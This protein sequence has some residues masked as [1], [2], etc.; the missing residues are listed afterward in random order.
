ML[1]QW[2]SCVIMLKK[3]VVTF[4]RMG[5]PSKE[6]LEKRHQY[7]DGMW[8]LAVAYTVC[9]AKS[10]FL[11]VLAE[12]NKR[13]FCI[14]ARDHGCHSN[15]RALRCWT[16]ECFATCNGAIVVVWIA[17]HC[18]CMLEGPFGC[19]PAETLFLCRIISS[20]AVSH[21]FLSDFI[22]LPFWK[23]TFGI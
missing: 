12:K 23:K 13:R 11:G 22:L 4:A 17:L 18:L 19:F 10:R 21:P 14:P 15:V 20:F 1:K 16:F 5:S 6:A 2:F 9:S 8:G 7:Y 3:T